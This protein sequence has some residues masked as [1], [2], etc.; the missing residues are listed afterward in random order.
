M[1]K[2][3]KRA[4]RRHHYRR[5]KKRRINQEY[6]GRVAQSD[7]FRGWTKPQLGIAVDTP[8]ICSCPGCGNPRKHFGEKTL[9]E[10]RQ[11]DSAKDQIDDYWNSED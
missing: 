1:F 5:L 10:V 4:E 11:D 9:A 3:T 7:I 6:W 2:S 8:C